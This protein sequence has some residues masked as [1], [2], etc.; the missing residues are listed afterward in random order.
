MAVKDESSTEVSAEICL[1]D[2]F[3]LKGLFCLMR[4]LFFLTA[5]LMIDILG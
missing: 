1:L 4:D 5:A 2:L 3:F